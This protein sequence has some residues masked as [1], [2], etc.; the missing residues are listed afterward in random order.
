MAPLFILRHPRESGDPVNEAIRIWAM[1]TKTPCFA[2]EHY[3]T[4][5][6]YWVPAFAG[7]TVGE[8]G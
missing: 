5:R 2:D 6:G 3:N 7:M 4:V 8:G 1:A